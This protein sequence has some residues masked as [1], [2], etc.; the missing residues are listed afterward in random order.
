MH[1]QSLIPLSQD[2]KIT[3]RLFPIHLPSIGFSQPH[4]VTLRSVPTQRD[5]LPWSPLACRRAQVGPWLSTIHGVRWLTHSHI[6][7]PAIFQLAHPQLALNCWVRFIAFS[8]V[9]FTVS[10]ESSLKQMQSL[11]PLLVAIA[12]R[13]KTGRMCVCGCG[14]VCAHTPH[15]DLLSMILNIL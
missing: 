10:P 3:E 4:G 13:R 15:L 2:F 8:V 6:C 1:N 9:L 12:L 14:C 11:W 5:V 7:I